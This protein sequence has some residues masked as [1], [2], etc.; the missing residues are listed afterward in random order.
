MGNPI[1]LALE[2]AVLLAGGSWACRRLGVRSRLG[3][4]LRLVWYKAHETQWKAHQFEVAEIADLRRDVNGCLKILDHLSTAGTGDW[5]QQWAYVREV[6]DE[7][8]K[9]GIC[10]LADAGEERGSLS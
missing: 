9:N 7:I 5:G 6:L 10:R 8:N 1:T 2:A 4:I 3:R